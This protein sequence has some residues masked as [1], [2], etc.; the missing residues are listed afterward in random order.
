MSR[1]QKTFVDA[2]AEGRTALICYLMAGVPSPEDFVKM[3][4]ACLEGGADVLEIG[5]PFSD[6]L[7]DGPVIQ[8]AAVRALENKVTPPMVMDMVR[9]LRSRTDRPIVLMGYYNPIFR[10]GEERFVDAC[11]SAGADGLIVPDLPL[12]ESASLRQTCQE[13]GLDLI[14]LTTPLTPDDRN[15]ELVHATSGFLYLVTRTGVTGGGSVM[16][17]DL[18]K[19]ISRTRSVDLHV[20]LAAGFGI[21]RPEQVR[22]ARDMGADGVIVGSALVSLTLNGSSADDLK[23]TVRRLASACD[24]ERP[25]IQ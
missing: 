18:R 20:P 24:A 6:P 13:K 2:R 17:E 14:Q 22:A 5:V 12:H 7:A 4:V 1:L 10:M 3:A 25:R 15:S 9:E 23:D 21:S 8:L 11:R 19:M 16:T